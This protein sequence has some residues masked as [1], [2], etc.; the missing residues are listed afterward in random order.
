MRCMR[1][2]ETVGHLVVA[3]L[4]LSLAASAAAAADLGPLPPAPP[5]VTPAPPPAPPRPVAASRPACILVPRPQMNL[6]GEEV[7]QYLLSWVCVSR[8]LYADRRPPDPV[9][10]RPWWYW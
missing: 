1:Q 2:S 8:G 5:S 4:A 7:N 6:A 9:P 3:G 10:P